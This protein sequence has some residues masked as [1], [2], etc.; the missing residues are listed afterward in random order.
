MKKYRYGKAKA[1]YIKRLL[2]SIYAGRVVGYR[3]NYR[4]LVAIQQGKI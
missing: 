1:K 4:A 3:Y 2:K